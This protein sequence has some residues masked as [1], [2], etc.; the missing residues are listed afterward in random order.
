[1]NKNNIQN[2]ELQVEEDEWD[3]KIDGEFDPSKVVPETIRGK[4]TRGI[5]KFIGRKGVHE[6]EEFEGT[7]VN[8]TTIE[9][10][11]SGAL[12]ERQ[13]KAKSNAIRGA[14]EEARQRR[15][16]NALEAPE[17]QSIANLLAMIGQPVAG[18]FGLEDGNENSTDH[19]QGEGAKVG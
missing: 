18:A 1:M 15:E 19:D 14:F 6:W 13:F 4:E 16:E 12:F 5:W 17:P 7:E 3:E 9:A 2:Q 11:G 8:Q 10:Q